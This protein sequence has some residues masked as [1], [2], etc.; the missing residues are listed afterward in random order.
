[1]TGLD[2][3]DTEIF[4][5]LDFNIGAGEKIGIVGGNA[6]G[7]SALFAMCAGILPPTKGLVLVNGIDPS[8]GKYAD[9]VRIRRKIGLVFQ[10]GILINNVSVFDNVALPLRYHSIFDEADIE[11]KVERA[12]K[13]FNLTEFE[14]KLPAELS[15]GVLKL[16]AYARAFIADPL[17]YLIDDPFADLDAKGTSLVKE[18]LI[19]L[20]GKEDVTVLIASS[21]EESIRIFIDRFIYLENK[22]FRLA[23]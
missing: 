12:L 10:E 20:S 3:E 21:D 15:K 7:K 2:I 5:I 23:E 18:F 17:I 9:V 22:T 6:T 1:M 8:K 13:K 11:I 16:A 14:D 19:Y 4:S